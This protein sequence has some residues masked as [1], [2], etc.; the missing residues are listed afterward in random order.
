MPSRSERASRRSR[1]RFTPPQTSTR[2]HPPK[3]QRSTGT[4]PH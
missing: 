3:I 1:A 2:S 4:F